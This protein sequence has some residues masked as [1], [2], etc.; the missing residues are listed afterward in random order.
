[1]QLPQRL[2]LRNSSARRYVCGIGAYIIAYTRV[3]DT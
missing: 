2:K 3:K 1:M